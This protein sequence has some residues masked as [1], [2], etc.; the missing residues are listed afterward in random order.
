MYVLVNNGYSVDTDEE[1]VDVLNDYF[2]KT[3]THSRSSLDI[4]LFQ[5]P[6]PVS[7]PEDLRSRR[8][9]KNIDTSKSSGPDSIST[10]MLRGSATSITPAI[11]RLF[12]MSI[13]FHQSGNLHLLPQF[14]IWRKIRPCQL[15]IHLTS[16]NTE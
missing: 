6:G 4:S 1:K 8:K 2:S 3:F 16:V 12:N 15:Q 5:T 9:L 7:C 11:T 10:K 14:K 13:A